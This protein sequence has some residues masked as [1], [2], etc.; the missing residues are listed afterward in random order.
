MEGHR[1]LGGGGVRV[2]DVEQLAVIHGIQFCGAALISA[3]WRSNLRQIPA[4]ADQFSK[5]GWVERSEPHH[6]FPKNF[7][8]MVGLASLDPPYSFIQTQKLIG[9]EIPAADGVCIALVCVPLVLVMKSARRA[10]YECWTRE[11]QYWS[12]G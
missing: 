7:N 9:P 1:S 4:R 12:G 6:F 5:V 11:P 2:C 8:F 10:D 3:A